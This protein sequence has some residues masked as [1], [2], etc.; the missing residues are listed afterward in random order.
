[1][2]RIGDVP[3]SQG[4]DLCDR[5]ADMGDPPRLFVAAGGNLADDLGSAGDIRG[6]LLE[7]C[8]RVTDQLHSFGHVAHGLL[9]DGATVAGR[10]RR[11]VQRQDNWCGMPPHQQLVRVLGLLYNAARRKTP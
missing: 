10:L 7:G 9:D 5:L 6:N 2:L 8:V 11:H 1:L 4:L 3:L